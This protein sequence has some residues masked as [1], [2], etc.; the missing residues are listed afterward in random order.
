MSIFLINSGYI[1]SII[2]Y[3]IGLILTFKE[4]MR[5]KV[6]DP[7]VRM[8]T[9]GILCSSLFLITLFLVLQTDMLLKNKPF[10]TF[11]FLWLVFDTVLGVFLITVQYFMR[12]TSCKLLLCEQLENKLISIYEN[13]HIV[14]T[15]GDN[16]INEHDT[17]IINDS[18]KD[19]RTSLDRMTKMPLQ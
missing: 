17:R 13:H 1:I 15:E 11:A 3:I 9:Y 2:I 8:F 19:I 18:L 16:I 7:Y 6:Q 10:T 14:H 5:I 12:I 4:L